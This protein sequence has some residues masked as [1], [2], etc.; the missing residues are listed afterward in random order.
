MAQK[1]LMGGNALSKQ[2]LVSQSKRRY[3]SRRENYEETFRDLMQYHV[4]EPNKIG[5][6]EDFRKIS[7]F[8]GQRGKISDELVEAL[9]QTMEYKEMIIEKIRYQEIKLKSGKASRGLMNE[10]QSGYFYYDKNGVLR[11]RDKST[12]RFL[13]TPE[14]YGLLDLS[15]IRV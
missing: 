3:D 8:K 6:V 4:I 13:K 14:Y 5:G 11:M 15:E 7:S 10:D 2:Q 1:T 12:G 9:E